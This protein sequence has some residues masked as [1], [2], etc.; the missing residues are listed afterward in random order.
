MATDLGQYAVLPNFL[1]KPPEY[2]IE[3]LAAAGNDMGQQSF[4]SS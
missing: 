2:A 3:R 1:V 4:T